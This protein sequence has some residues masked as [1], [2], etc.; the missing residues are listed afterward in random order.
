MSAFDVFRPLFT[1]LHDRDSSL[2]HSSSPMAPLLTCC[3]PS[4]SASFF[5]PPLSFFR[6]PSFPHPPSSTFCIDLPGHFFL[7]LPIYFLDTFAS[8][9]FV[10][11]N[12]TGMRSSTSPRK[13][14][15]PSACFVPCLPKHS[16]LQTPSSLTLPFAKRVSGVLFIHSS[17]LVH[18]SVLPPFGPLYTSVCQSSLPPH[19]FLIINPSLYIVPSL[20]ILPSFLPPLCILPSSSFGTNTHQFIRIQSLSSYL[21]NGLRFSR[22]F[23]RQ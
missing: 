12:P 16:W 4:F 17:F 1:A 14:S 23:G 21:H 11:G 10:T 13:L 20:Y 19:K 5:P 3:P 8:F 18:P 22:N 7:G 15:F 6:L 9:G 2:V